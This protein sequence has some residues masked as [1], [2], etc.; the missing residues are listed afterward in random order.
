MGDEDDE[1]EYM[2]VEEEEVVAREGQIR[3]S[4][5]NNTVQ[6]DSDSDDADEDHVMVGAAGQDVEE[7]SEEEDEDYESRLHQP[8]SDNPLKRRPELISSEEPRKKK[9]KAKPDPNKL[10]YE[11]DDVPAVEDT[12]AAGEP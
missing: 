1:D 9:K 11:D 2:E 6:A 12:A 7:K 5:P 4:L 10:P 3:P 8:V